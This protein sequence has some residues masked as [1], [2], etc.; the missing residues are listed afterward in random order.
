MF[1]SV[2]LRKLHNRYVLR[3][4]KNSIIFYKLKYLIQTNKL[5]EID[6]FTKHVIVE[7]HKQTKKR[8]EIS[9][10]IKYQVSKNEF[11]DKILEL[12]LMKSGSKID[13]KLLNLTSQIQSLFNSELLSKSNEIGYV[14]YQLLYKRAK[15]EE[16]VNLSDEQFKNTKGTIKLSHRHVW[17]Y[18]DKPHLLLG[19][20]SGSGKSYLLFSIVWKMMA[21]TINE[22]IFVCD[23]K[24][25]ELEEISKNKFKL[26]NVAKNVTDIVKSINFVEEEMNKRYADKF[27]DRKAVFL[28]ID[29]FAAL[30]LILDKN[31][32]KELTKRLKSIILKGRAANIH[33]LV[34]MQRAS[35]AN[36]DLDIRDNC[37]IRIGLGNLSQENF[38]MIFNE[39]RSENEIITRN[40]GEGYILID[41]Q[42]VSLFEAPKI[43]K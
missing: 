26:K 41:G 16:V 10:I 11:G 4:F 2:K 38:K 5:Y 34:A 35:S 32:V 9:S 13:E 40:I 20:N 19:G 3:G 21:E 29:E 22:N 31:E 39:T 1:I 43:V 7:N 8:I 37:A 6:Q 15:N 25:D 17:E 28:V 36:M 42:S 27:R 23:G 30:S 33:V 24:F 14:S 18:I 12:R